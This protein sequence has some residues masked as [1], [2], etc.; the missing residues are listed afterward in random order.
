MGKINREAK[1]LAAKLW[2]KQLSLGKKGGR[3]V[4]IPLRGQGGASATDAHFGG[5]RERENTESGTV[6]RWQRGE[7]QPRD[8]QRD[9]SGGG[10]GG[11]IRV[12]K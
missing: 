3:G 12:L 5:R 11:D 4:V 7:L 2:R 9:G 6:V 10:V 8:A 1:P